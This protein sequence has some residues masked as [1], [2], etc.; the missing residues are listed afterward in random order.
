MDTEAFEEAVR[1][2]KDRVHT[3]ASYMLRDADSARDVA[4][5]ALM[6]L[7]THRAGV[8]PAG[9]KNWLLRTTHNLCID[10]MRK[11][12]VRSEVE[13]GVVV[14]Q[15]PDPRPDPER[16]AESGD[17]AS[18]IGAA[19]AELAPRDRAVVVMRE[20]QGLAYEDIARALDLPLGTLKARLHRARERLRERL[21]AAGV[22]P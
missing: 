12:R 10:R 11:L 18:R 1:V 16:R 6:R 17:L 14:F 22:T 21:T 19:L 13:A 7:W 5:E 3:Y 20:I 2:H 8:E 15:R 4:Q 9:A